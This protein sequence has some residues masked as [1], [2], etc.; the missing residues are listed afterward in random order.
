MPHTTRHRPRVE[1]LE[2]RWTP[3]AEFKGALGGWINVQTDSR[4]ALHAVGDGVVDDTAAL[5]AALNYVATSN[6]YETTAVV[7]LPA[8]TYK[9]TSTLWD[10][11]NHGVAM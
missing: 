2:A 3:A 4:L 8:G 7:Y 5:Q 10:W 11:G 1:E 9:V 6:Q